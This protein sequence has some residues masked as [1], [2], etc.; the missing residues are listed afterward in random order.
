MKHL[1]SVH[2]LIIMLALLATVWPC[3]LGFRGSPG[4][5]ALKGATARLWPLYSKNRHADRVKQI[6]RQRHFFVRRREADSMKEPAALEQMATA[7]RFMLDDVFGR[8]LSQHLG[9]GGV[10]PYMAGVP[11]KA[12]HVR[13]YFNLTSIKNKEVA[14]M[15]H[16]VAYSPGVTR[17]K[18]QGRVPIAQQPFYRYP[19]V[20]E[21]EMEFNKAAAF[22]KGMP[23]LTPDLTQH[24]RENRLYSGLLTEVVF[25]HLPKNLIKEMSEMEIGAKQGRVDVARLREK[26]DDQALPEATDA[27]TTSSLPFATP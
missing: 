16:S 17:G 22:R 5:T 23:P 1:Y 10:I 14:D 11:D 27:S 25:K 26:K 6:R 24:E 15:C 3:A 19:E 8:P 13:R 21:D 2:F 20:Q 12:A 7:Q 9:D 18:F 4:T